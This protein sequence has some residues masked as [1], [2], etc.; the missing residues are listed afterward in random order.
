MS[1]GAKLFLGILTILPFFYIIAFIAIIIVMVTQIGGD[2]QSGPPVALFIAH[3]FFMLL[4][5]GL[6][7]YYIIHALRNTRLPQTERLLWV[8]I[9]FVGNMLVMPIYWFLHV[10]RESPPLMKSS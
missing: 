6:I 2:T 8:I 4:I 7:V 1:T 10:W 3:G 5:L 9:I